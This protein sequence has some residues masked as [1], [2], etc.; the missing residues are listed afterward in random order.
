[1]GDLPGREAQEAEDDVLD[2][3]REEGISARPD[4]L[5]L[6]ADQIEDDREV[7]DAERP[8]C[9][10]VLPDLPQVLAVA[11]QAEDLAELAGFDELAGASG[12]RGG[13]AGGG[14]A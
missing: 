14:R 11:V 9:V 10:L 12:R 7:V 5:G 6:L 2:A 8:Q 3:W 4:L 13:R 1:M